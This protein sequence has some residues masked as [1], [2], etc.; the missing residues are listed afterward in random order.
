MAES[1][2]SGM[3]MDERRK[4]GGERGESGETRLEFGARRSNIR[5]GFIYLVLNCAISCFFIVVF[6]FF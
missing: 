4:T 3:G 5:F 2:I 6:F 1:W